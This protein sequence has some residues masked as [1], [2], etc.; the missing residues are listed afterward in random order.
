MAH[1][2]IP[3]FIPHLGCP[4]RCVFC[5]QRTIS[6]ASVPDPEKIRAD[7]DRALSTLDGN[8]VCEIAFFGGSF[9]G[10]GIPLMTELLSAAADCIVK[11]CG[12]IDSIRLSTRPDYIDEAVLSVLKQY[13]VKTVEL[14]IQ[15]TDDNVLA[16]SRRGHTA[17]QALRACA[18]VKAAG[19][20]LV[21]Q[22]MVG[23]PGSTEEAEIR[24][25]QDICKAGADAA[26]IYPTVVFYGTELAQMTERGEYEPLDE[27]EAVRRT[28]H[29]LKVLDEAKVPC[30]RIGLCASEN[31]AS[32][33]LVLG[34]ANHPALGEMVRGE[35]LFE[36]ICQQLAGMDV[37]GRDVTV[38]VPRGQLSQAV[39]QHRYNAD[40]LTKSYGLRSVSFREWDGAIKAVCPQPGTGMDDQGRKGAK[41]CT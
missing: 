34:G 31:L 40:R 9:T 17:E 5:D 10:I 24:T 14:G 38:L 13:P 3:V 7:L 23:L 39:G 33:E 20:A 19:F 32:P 28:A 36:T 25:A 41:L 37:R 26:R 4:H 18:A 16:L 21:G 6:G 22:M 27:K 11:S 12:K 8:D 2:N 30:I 29:I 15:S 35:I 1:R